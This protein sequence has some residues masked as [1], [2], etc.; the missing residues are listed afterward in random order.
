MQH[1]VPVLA[2]LDGQ[3]VA[4][5]PSAA[6]VLGASGAGRA[7]TTAELRQDKPNRQAFR[8]QAR[9]PVQVVLDGVHQGY[10]VG[11]L[12]RLC[13]A[14][15]CERLVICGRDGTRGTR[16]LV[17]AAQGTHRWV[18]WQQADSAVEV[19]R[20]ARADGYQVV[21]VEQTSTAVDVNDFQPC[22]PVCLVLGSER[23]GVSQAVLDLADAAV[24]LPMRG[25]A[26]SLNVATAGAIVLHAL[27]VD[28]SR[29]SLAP[30][31]Q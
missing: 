28:Q 12:F 4:R 8:T 25:M 30:L 26:N 13:D 16:K 24:A 19:V 27:A 20:A 29:H 7:L 6:H 9:L 17:Q 23:S 2:R 31:C 22:Y 5:P 21:A 1:K 11:A 10:N 14:F 15:L 18:T 3:G